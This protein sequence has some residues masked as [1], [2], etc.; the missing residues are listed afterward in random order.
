MPYRNISLVFECD[1]ATLKGAAELARDYGGRLTLIDVVKGIPDHVIR[2]GSRSV[3]VRKLVIHDRTSALRA[4]AAG[5]AARGVR[6]KTVLAVGDAFAEIIRDV[7]E[8][9]RDLV[10]MTSDGGRGLRHRFLGSTASHLVR[11]CPVPVLVMKPGRRMNFKNVAVAIDVEGGEAAADLNARLLRAA[12]EL[13]QRNGAALHVVHAWR[14]LGESIFRRHGGLTD[15][16]VS[17]MKD[18]ERARRRGLVERL[19]APVEADPMH[20]HVIEGDAP[21]VIPK[22]VSRNRAD[23]LV[24]GTVSR[25]GIAGVIIGNT[26]ERILDAI[27]CSLLVLKPDGFISPLAP[28]LRAEWAAR[29][30]SPER[31][32]Q[33]RGR[34]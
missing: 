29:T 15:A 1:A 13:A 19:V 33:R 18:E 31:R 8:H 11:K 2:L 22:F 9:R 4:A 6:A 7:Y 26:A 5:I 28:P 25:A 21:V 34:R 14:L 32:R 12:A 17:Q 16:R 23:L 3:N 30:K 10:I 24:M 27:D 20:L